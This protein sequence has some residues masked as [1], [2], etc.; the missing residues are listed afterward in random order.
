M[1]EIVPAYGFAG[2]GGTVISTFERTREQL[3]GLVPEPAGHSLGRRGRASSTSSSPVTQ[4]SGNDLGRLVDALI[5]VHPIDPHPYANGLAAPTAG[6]NAGR[7]AAGAPAR[8]ATGDTTDNGGRNAAR[9][10]AG[11]ASNRTGT[12]ARVPNA[13]RLPGQEPSR[14]ERSAAA[15]TLAL[16][17]ARAHLDALDHLIAAVADLDY[18]ILLGR[19]EVSRHQQLRAGEIGPDNLNRRFRLADDL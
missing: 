5:E 3:A 19:E 8:N 15:R 4:R 12:A 17:N 13:S 1:A 2:V 18:R 14:P 10:S 6:S 16:A 11:D 9:E 7:N